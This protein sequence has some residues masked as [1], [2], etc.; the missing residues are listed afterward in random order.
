M[1][2]SSWRRGSFTR[3]VLTWAPHHIRSAS[4]VDFLHSISPC[5]SAT[6]AGSCSGSR[7]IHRLNHEPATSYSTTSIS[8][9]DSPILNRPAANKSPAISPPVL[10][11]PLPSQQNVGLTQDSH[12]RSRNN[13]APFAA[14]TQSNNRK[15]AASSGGRSGGSI[16]KGNGRLSHQLSGASDAR[17]PISSSISP[18][19]P[20]TSSPSPLPSPTDHSCVGYTLVST[21]AELELMLDQLAAAAI[22]GRAG[23]GGSSGGGSGPSGGKGGGSSGILLGDGIG[24]LGPLAIDCEGFELGRLGGK[25]CLLQVGHCGTNLTL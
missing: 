22:A 9:V 21:P 20:A 12:P 5:Q 23:S 14:V 2:S 10:P 8:H 1:T 24:G 4:N 3:K 15:H 16:S 11:P 6:L 13:P 18:A 17:P 7:T 25:L 19:V